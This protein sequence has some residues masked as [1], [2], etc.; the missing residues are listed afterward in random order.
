MRVDYDVLVIGA[1]AAGYVA[2]LHAAGQGLRT[3]LVE[4]GQ[5]GGTCLN[6]GCIPT[7]ALVSTCQLLQNIR[8]SERFGIKVGDV[9]VDYPQVQKRKEQAVLRLRKGI[10]FLFKKHKLEV[11]SG[12][13]TFVDRYTVEV[14][15]D[16]ET[17]RLTSK[18]MIIATGS[19]PVSLFGL[20]FGQ[21]IISSTEALELP[22]VPKSLLVVG[23]GVIGCEMGYIFSTLGAAVT[24]VEAANQ[25]LPGEDPEV[26][27]LLQR[28]LRKQGISIHTQTLLDNLELGPEGVHAHL[29]KGDQTF[30]KVLIAVGRKPDYAQLGLEKVGVELA[31]KGGIP[32]DENMQTNIEGIYAIG[33]VTGKWQ[34]AHVGSAEGIAAVN[35]ILGRPTPVDY[36][37]IPRSIFTSPEIGAVGLTLKQAEDLGF[38]CAEASVPFVANGRAVAG[39]ET[40]GFA[41]I[42]YEKDTGKILGL[43]LIGAGATELVA[44]GAVAMQLGATVA[45][46]AGT[47]H[48]HPTFAESIQEAARQ[49]AGIGF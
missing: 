14:V 49:G 48:A 46:L 15:G 30:E 27:A 39:D 11:Y 41:K 19:H 37:V 23:G 13:A 22:Q 38:Q 2:A 36:R 31:P 29:P 32:V 33:D 6:A 26:S 35:A 45:D 24:I 17:Q 20:E 7:K 47:I 10:E 44:E 16:D 18:N 3:A 12:C 5:V 42:V 8:R 1:G 4:K 25:L 28:S 9:T 40:E 34:L 43:H 21:E